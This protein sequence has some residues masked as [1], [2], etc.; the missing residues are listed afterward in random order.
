MRHNTLMPI[1]TFMTRFYPSNIFPR[2]LHSEVF[3]S[4][5]SLAI[6]SGILFLLNSC[7]EDPTQIGKKILPPSDFVSFISTDTIGV[8]TYTMYSDSIESNNP[9]TSYLGQLYDPYF[10]T[11]TAGFVTQI[12][13]GS[14]WNED[15]FFI[16]SVKLFLKLLTLTGNVSVPQYLNLSEINDVLSIDS[17]YYSGQPVSLTGY[18]ER[19]ILLPELQADTINNIEINI[20]VSFGD[21][22]T[23]DTSKLFYSSNEPDFRS[24]FKGLYFHLSPSSNPIFA[25]L[26]IDPPG[27]YETYSNYFVLY[28]HDESMASKEFYFILDAFSRNACFNRYVHDFSTAEPDKLIK[29]INDG[30]PDSLAY[31]QTMNGLYTKIQIPGLKD[32]KKDIDMSKIMINKARLIFPAFYDGEVYKPS[33]LPKQIYLRYLTSS[34]SR[35]LIPDYIISSEFYDGTPD[36][37]AG[38]FNLNMAS[39]V[40]NYLED[41]SGNLTSDLELFLLPSSTNNVILKANN[42]T[43]PVR[44]ELT[45]TK[46]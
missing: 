14:E 41:S 25:S 22:L 20:P 26:S 1:T 33:T 31:V 35:Y 3:F 16:D 39:Y 5:L 8:K 18:S 46:F 4:N 11:T 9:S 42:S 2:R 30:Q 38:V 23:R 17:T 24:F 28:M 44:F 10:G 27:T 32:L 36:T 6:L 15:Y 7:E 40:Q 29:H 19:N 37:T 34:R 21:Y 43:N 12:R 45:Y 13:L